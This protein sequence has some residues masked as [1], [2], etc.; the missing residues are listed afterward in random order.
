M[1]KIVIIEDNEI[2]RQELAEF[3]NKNGYEAYVIKTFE[4]AAAET[5]AQNPDCVILDLNFS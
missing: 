1:E 2:I 4:T 3:L 5:L